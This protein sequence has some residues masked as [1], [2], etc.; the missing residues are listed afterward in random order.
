M[1]KNTKHAA[2]KFKKDP[3]KVESSG[4]SSDDGEEGILSDKIEYNMPKP[5]VHAK[6]ILKDNN[7]TFF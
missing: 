7:F 5:G 1:L 3:E 2:K 6:V 4:A